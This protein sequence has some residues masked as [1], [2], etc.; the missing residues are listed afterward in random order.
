MSSFTQRIADLTDSSLSPEGLK[1]LHLMEASAGTGKTYSI[2][3]IYLRLV[4]IEA[5]SVQQILTVT[6]TKDATKE[7]RD[8]LQGILRE[9]LDYCDDPSRILDAQHRTKIMVDVAKQEKGESCVR[10]RLQLA[11]LDFDMA[12]I[13][14]IHGFCQ[15]VLRRFAFETGQPFDMEPSNSADEDI[16]QLCKDWWRHYTYQMDESLSSFLAQSGRFSLGKITELAKKLIAKPDAIV[17]IDGIRITALEGYI[18]TALE[19]ELP[20]T[21]EETAPY[22]DAKGIIK[23]TIEHFQRTMAQCRQ[24]I[25]S[26]D[27]PIALWALNTLCTDCPVIPIDAYDSAM[28]IKGAC[29]ACMQAVAKGTRKTSFSYD[30]AG[31]LRSEN[32]TAL[33]P[34]HTTAITEIARQAE[35]ID[36]V[37]AAYQPF[38]IKQN[39]A[40]RSLERIIRHA[41]SLE[42]LCAAD[43]FSAIKEIASMKCGIR[44][45]I[46]GSVNTFNPAFTARYEQ[47]MRDIPSVSYQAALQIKSRYQETRSIAHT[48]SFNDYLINLRHALQQRDGLVTILREEFRAALI[49]EFQDT[50]PIQWGIF[51]TTFRDAGI[52]CFLVGDP[53]QAIYRFRNGDVETYLKATKP[54]PPSA[55][56]PL[57]VNYRSETR[58]IDAVNQIFMDREDRPTFG[59]DITYSQPLDAAGKVPSDSLLIDG[60]V[61][62]QPF[63]LMLLEHEG[64]KGIPGKTSKTAERAYR[65]TAREVAR[66]LYQEKPTIAGHVARPGDIAI[67]INTHAQGEAIAEELKAL[68]IPSVRQGTGDVWQTEE[69]HNLWGMLEV[70]LDPRNINL[71]RG[72]L[73]SPWGAIDAD[74]LKAL[75]A[76]EAISHMDIAF[77]IDDF[78]ALFVDLNDIWMRRGFP[79][80]FRTLMSRFDIQNKLLRHPDKQGQRRMANI[81]QLSELIERKLLDARKTPEGILAW[82]RRQFDP[83]TA[84]GGDESALRLESDDEAVRIMTVFTSKGLQFPIVFAPTLFMMKPYLPESTYEFH[85]DNGDLNIVMKGKDNEQDDDNKQRATK[86]IE[87]EFVRQI[88]VALTRAVHRTVILAVGEDNT[89]TPLGVLGKLLEPLA[90]QQDGTQ[91]RQSCA[92]AISMA[93]DA[94][95]TTTAPAPIPVNLM[96]APLTR[97]AIDTTKGHGSFSSIAPQAEHHTKA[98][99]Q[100]THDTIKDNDETAVG[101]SIRSQPDPESIF[102]FPSG[103]HTGT[104]WHSIFETLA[105]DADES[106]IQDTV[107]ERLSAYGFLNSEV[108]RNSRINATTTMVNRVLQTTLPPLLPAD[109]QHPFSLS[110]IEASDRKNEWAFSF[111][112]KSGQRTQAIC[113]AIT[114][115]PQ[116]REFTDAVVAWDHPLPAGYLTGFVDLLFRKNGAYYIVDWKSNRRGGQQADFDRDGMLNEMSTHRYWL[117]YL[118]YS[119]AVHQYLTHALPDY[120][121]EKH[122]GGVYYIFL[123]GVDGLHQANQ[124]NG[125]YCDRPPLAL[126]NQ[127][128]AILGDFA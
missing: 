22:P 94:P 42:P 108:W 4:L 116:Y 125:V 110:E 76:G 51:D 14:T 95:V 33:T 8:R 107:V 111:S 45:E 6:F 81:V 71:V 58:L 79:A 100:T 66:V 34:T 98:S 101:D 63:K 1:R 92:I 21:P 88:Y 20:V 68:G 114:A 41:S 59:D 126:L 38:N 121:Y 96:A 69:A 65:L 29:D 60:S 67:L 56:Y 123:R 90:Q 78:V 47:L 82:V 62:P 52:P 127:L 16:E 40:I 72:A 89:P 23:Q 77:S 27:T 84:D 28:Q 87:Q 106:L 26:H 50:D 55:R 30:E 13:F 2:Q 93:D 19:S 36:K 49:D 128:S 32:C 105:F 113:D 54:I 46:T 17:E 109:K 25:Q 75:N 7:L 61:D 86:E 124:T 91:D 31:C 44:K 48:A 120:D 53:K 43:L 5:L 64:K 80:M 99:P 9:A 117:Q 18:Q 3:T 10:K 83:K 11:L 118:I 119:V 37:I 102:A 122:F 112:A 24:A 39:S 73:I 104:C 35:P 12:A 57:T 70:V 103:A 15:R 74:Q 97:P 115:Y 85:D